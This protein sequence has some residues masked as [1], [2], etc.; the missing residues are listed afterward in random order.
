MID[1]E[2]SGLPIDRQ[3]ELI[4]LN[5]ST[6]YYQSQR[7]DR[8]NQLLMR[9][10]DE[11]YTR[12]PFYGIRRITQILKR[13][14]H[15]V[16]HKRI[17]RLMRRMGLEAIYPKPNLSKASKA[18]PKYPYL[19]RG[20]KIAYPDQVW[21]SDITYIRTRYG[22]VY[23]TAVIDW[24]SRYVLS[25]EVST[26]LDTDFCVKALKKA[27]NIAKPEIFN[28]DQ[29]VQFTS[30]EFTGCLANAGVRISMDGRGRALDNIFV[31]RLWRNVKYEKVYFND[32]EAVKDVVRD[33]EEYFV[34]YNLERP[35]QSLGYETPTEVY[36]KE[37]K[38]DVRQNMP[39]V[40]SDLENPGRF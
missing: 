40:Y 24:F 15:L 18:H 30:D 16:N 2:H 34:F 9:L 26:S 4:G 31:E 23:L 33:M 19:L 28:T 7:D 17:A 27:L 12:H 35:H 37:R 6:Y 8:Y 39:I 1:P 21:S 14:G 25:F 36:L 11:E 29:G 13:Q 20:L 10:I 22:F 3:C 5:R 38:T 32:Y